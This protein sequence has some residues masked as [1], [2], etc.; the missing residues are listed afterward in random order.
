MHIKLNN[1]VPE[2]YSLADLRRDNPDTSFPDVMTE[3]GLAERGIY[4]VTV[5]SIP[6]YDARTHS[7]KQSVFYKVRGKWQM[8]YTTEPLPLSI[9]A[10]NVKADRDRL[11]T[12][13]D[14]VV[15]RAYETQS[16][17]PQEW[18][19]YRQQLRDLPTQPN[20]P[21]DTVWPTKP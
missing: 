9:A 1:G 18:A 3:E 19:T 13:T 4:S 12:E 17:V 2:I 20:F 8:H 21:H 14:W 15:A 5:L 6:S 7:L 11:L 16:A 10:M